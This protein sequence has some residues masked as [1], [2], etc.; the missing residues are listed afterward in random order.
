MSNGPSLLHDT[1]LN[2]Q[3]RFSV[4]TTPPTMWIFTSITLPTE[5][6]GKG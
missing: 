3:Q 4:P 6:H 2:L 5:W 1:I